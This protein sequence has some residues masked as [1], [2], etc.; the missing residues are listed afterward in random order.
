MLGASLRLF[1]SFYRPLLSLLSGLEGLFTLL[2]LGVND[3]LGEAVVTFDFS[4]VFG[5]IDC[6]MV[7]CCVDCWVTVIED[8]GCCIMG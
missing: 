8:G 4:G 2:L 3:F 1:S 6:G 5:L 7:A